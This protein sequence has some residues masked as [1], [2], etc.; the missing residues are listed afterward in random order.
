MP[1]NQSKVFMPGTIPLIVF[2]VAIVL[3]TTLYI[4]GCS[5]TKNWYPMF[6]IFPALLLIFFAYM[7]ISRIDEDNMV[8]G[9]WGSADAWLFMA[10]F[11]LTSFIALPLVFFH[12]RIINGTGLGL[13]LA[14]D[15]LYGI[16]FGLYIWLNRRESSY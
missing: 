2:S 12:C 5:I 11:A 3:G 8:E 6:V 16:G 7:F 15:V 4:V 14:G 1:E 9:G 10:V 13:H